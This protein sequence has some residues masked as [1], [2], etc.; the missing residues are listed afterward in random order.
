MSKTSYW[1]KDYLL[2]FPEKNPK[3]LDQ[4]EIIEILD[5]AKA[6]DPSWHEAKINANI[7]N[8]EMSYEESVSYFKRLKKLEKI[9]RTNRLNASLL[10]IDIKKRVS[11][12]SGERKSSENLKGS[13]LWCWYCDNNTHNTADCKVIAKSKQQ[14]KA[15]LK[16]KAGSGKKS[17]A[18][19]IL[20][21]EINALKRQLNPEKTASSKKK[22][23]E[24]ILFV[25]TEIILITDNDEGENQ[26]YLFTFSKPF[27]SVV[28]CNN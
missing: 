16:T 18:F 3:Q 25:C 22:K 14:K 2:I 10:P 4:D 8:F 27:V 11:V 13:S 20:F 21:E 9:R 17:L 7:E 23:V 1:Q 26:G 24:S 15:Q 28:N 6:T 5:Q 19:H 12:T